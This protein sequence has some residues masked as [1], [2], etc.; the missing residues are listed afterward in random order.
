M[1]PIG[2]L[3]N[4]NE[5]TFKP[6]TIS[7]VGYSDVGEEIITDI[8]FR[9]KPPFRFVL[10]MIRAGAEVTVKQPVD[11]LNYL[12]Q[13]VLK[14]DKESWEK[15]LDSEDVNV[16]WQTIVD[17]YVELIGLYSGNKKRPLAKAS[18]SRGGPS[19]TKRTSSGA[20]KSRAST[21]KTSQRKIG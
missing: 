10:D 8:R 6:H 1:E 20:A 17:V 19:S 2:R 14:D 15:L 4:I 21:S 11:A 7:V 18:S 5:D 12:D 13:C 3:K 16:E 9:A